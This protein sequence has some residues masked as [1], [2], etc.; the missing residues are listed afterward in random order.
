MDVC[1]LI[2]TDL[3]RWCSTLSSSLSKSICQP[4]LKLSQ[5]SGVLQML[6]SATDISNL[7][8]SINSK[9]LYVFSHFTGGLAWLGWILSSGHC[10][11]S[12][13]KIK[14]LCVCVFL[15]LLCVLFLLCPS[16]VFSLLSSPPFTLP[17]HIM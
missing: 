13:V 6:M 1:L 7:S 14:R 9:S 16:Y 4:A 3:M 11:F 2:N 15:P 5:S 12:S 17:S 8:S 10:V